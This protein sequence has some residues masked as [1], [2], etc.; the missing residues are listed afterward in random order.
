VYFAPAGSAGRLI[1]DP[2]AVFTGSIGGGNAGVLELATATTASSLYGFG[3]T[4]SNFATLAFDSPNWTVEGSMASLGTMA[5]TGFVQGDAIDVKDFQAVSYSF[6]SNVLTLY[7]GQ[8]TTMTLNVV[9]TAGQ[10]FALSAY[11]IGGTNIT[12]CFAAGTR[13]ATPMGDVPVD[14]LMPGDLVRAQFAGETAIQW[15]GHRRVDCARH[16]DPRSV[17]PVR[18]SAGAFGAGLPVRDLLLSPNHAV[19]VCGELIPVRHLINGLSVV[20]EQVD[21]IVYYHVELAEHD[22]LIAEGQPAESYLDIGDRANFGNADNEVR[23]FP[24]F[25]SCS[26]DAAAKW[27]MRGCAPLLL[28]GPR[29][30]AVR[31]RVIALA[32]AMPIAR[33]A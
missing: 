19:Y 18:V 9:G 14:S 24:D 1:V 8:T 28:R 17:W 10:V 12:E 20:Q 31:G 7:S 2:G 13:I 16:P 29:L 6:S 25:A 32:A 3:V 22:L 11:G 26:T 5:I 27:E 30:E 33:A 15:I 21:E 4:I 23:L